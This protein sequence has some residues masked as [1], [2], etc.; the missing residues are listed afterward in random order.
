MV[1]FVKVKNRNVS[2][3]TTQNF[4]RTLKNGVQR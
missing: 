2:V 3:Y 4:S 1:K